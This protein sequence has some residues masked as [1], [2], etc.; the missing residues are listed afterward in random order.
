MISR[1][2]CWSSPRRSSGFDSPLRVGGSWRMSTSW[3]GRSAVVRFSGEGEGREL[4]QRRRWLEG[5]LLAQPHVL[6]LMR[7]EGGFAEA[8]PPPLPF[9]AGGVVEQVGQ[10]ASPHC[11]VVRVGIGPDFAAEAVET[12]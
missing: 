4:F 12:V 7:I 2:R 3:F 11:G 1:R 9:D 10:P 5:V 6:L 8:A